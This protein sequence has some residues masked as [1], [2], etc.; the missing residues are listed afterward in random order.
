MQRDFAVLTQARRLKAITS[1]PEN[2]GDRLI[3]PV[4]ALNANDYLHYRFA[5]AL[6]S[7]LHASEKGGGLPLA[8]WWGKEERYCPLLPL[9]MNKE[10][11]EHH[12]HNITII[13]DS[14]SMGG[15]AN[16]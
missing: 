13:G 8:F 2:G 14:I 12:P 7:I 9:L 16:L 15:R 5:I 10:L 11:Q 6:Q 1:E 4:G 3:M